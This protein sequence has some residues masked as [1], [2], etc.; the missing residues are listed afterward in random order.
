MLS[1]LHRQLPG[2]ALLNSAGANGGP[3]LDLHKNTTHV[4]IYLST[5]SI[6]N[7]EC[8]NRLFCLSTGIMH[9]QALLRAVVGPGEGLEISRW[10]WK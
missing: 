6:A 7:L 8:V 3:C 2:P 10:G 4:A 1:N 5:C 9:H